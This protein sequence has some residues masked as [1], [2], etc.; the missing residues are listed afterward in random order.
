MS[1]C[2]VRSEMEFIDPKVV[3]RFEQPTTEV[4]GCRIAIRH[5]AIAKTWCIERDRLLLAL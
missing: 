4:F 1:A 5:E 3:D 2:V